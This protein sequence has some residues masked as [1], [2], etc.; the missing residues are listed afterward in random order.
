DSGQLTVGQD[1]FE[2]RFHAESIDMGVHNRVWIRHF[3]IVGDSI[4]RIPPLALSPRDFADEWI[5][6]PW[7][8][9]APWSA[10]DARPAPQPKHDQLRKIGFFSYQSLRRCSDR[11]DHYQVGLLGEN[12]RTPR[13]LHIVGEPGYRVTAV[14]ASL[15][16]S[17]DGEDLLEAIPTPLGG[18]SRGAPL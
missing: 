17:C 12:D 14:S 9:A 7:Q 15:D 16:A 4:A 3:R 18:D 13:Y 5:V 10:A 6:S 1:E 11:P 8:E 2:L